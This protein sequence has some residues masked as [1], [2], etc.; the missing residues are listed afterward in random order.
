MGAASER[1][2][3]GWRVKGTHFD[4]LLLLDELL[5]L[6]CDHA[7]AAFRAQGG[8]SVLRVSLRLRSL[9]CAR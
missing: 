9:L 8:G 6:G 2:G 5:L 7:G 4:K 1:E 3:S